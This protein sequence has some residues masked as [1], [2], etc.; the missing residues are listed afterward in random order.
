RTNGNTWT[1]ERDATNRN[2]PSSASQVI[3]WLTEPGSPD[4]GVQDVQTAK[5][6][7]EWLGGLKGNPYASPYE[8]GLVAGVTPLLSVSLD[9]VGYV[10][11][12]IPAY[13][14]GVDKHRRKSAWDSLTDSQHVQEFVPG[15]FKV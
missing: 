6:A 11:T 14:D 12:L 8:N 1:S 4:I 10:S 9:S 13:R 7:M 3:T 15:I 2:V 5:Q